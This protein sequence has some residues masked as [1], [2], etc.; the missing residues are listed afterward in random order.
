MSFIVCSCLAVTEEASIKT[1]T[2]GKGGIVKSSEVQR[3]TSPASSTST[4][5][6]FKVHCNLIHLPAWERALLKKNHYPP[7]NHHASHF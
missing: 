6:P 3:A 7:C 4:T 2:V 1:V 5:T